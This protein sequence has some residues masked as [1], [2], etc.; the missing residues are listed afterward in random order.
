MGNDNRIMGIDEL[1]EYLQMS[2]STL[3]KLSQAG[4]IPCQKIGRY[5]RYNREFIDEWIAT[6]GKPDDHATEYGAQ[7]AAPSA[8][9]QD[10]DDLKRYFSVRQARLLV[11]SSIHSISDLLLSLATNKGKSDLVETLGITPEQ[12]DGIATRVTED[13]Q[14]NRTGGQS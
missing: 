12:L 1:A 4:R 11:N 5:W 2:R 8:G 14:A 3:Y 6:F 7:L 10:N 13:L 9:H